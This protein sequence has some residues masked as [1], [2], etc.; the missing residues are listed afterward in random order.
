M[1]FLTGSAPYQAVR[2]IYKEL[3]QMLFWGYSL[4]NIWK[5]EASRITCYLPFF[6]EFD[7]SLAEKDAIC[8]SGKLE[9][10]MVQE[11]HFTIQTLVSLGIHEAG[12]LLVRGI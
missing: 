12:K 8:F 6:E 5:N 2:T 3:L 4:R 11:F 1:D 10:L 9:E 7:R